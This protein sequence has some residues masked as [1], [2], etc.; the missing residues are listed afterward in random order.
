MTMFSS[1]TPLALRVLTVPS[2]RAEMILVFQ[3]AWMMPIRRAEPIDNH[4]SE[5]WKFNAE[6]EVAYRHSSSPRLGL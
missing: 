6:V 3:R 4:I 2:T 5:G 1:L